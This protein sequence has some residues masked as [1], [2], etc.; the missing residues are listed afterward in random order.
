MCRS[1]GSDVPDEAKRAHAHGLQVGVPFRRS[2]QSGAMRG[3]EGGWYLLVISK[4]VPKIWARTNSAMVGGCRWR[5][6]GVVDRGMAEAE[7]GEG[8]LWGRFVG[9]VVRS[10]AGNC[11]G[12]DFRDE[13]RD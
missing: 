7:V 5:S 10:G 4:V 8:C 1:E 13:S 3:R 2:A 11:S 6:G 9:W 12:E